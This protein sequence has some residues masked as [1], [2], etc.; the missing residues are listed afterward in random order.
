MLHST[1]TR[2]QLI[3]A[4]QSVGLVNQ[5]PPEDVL[6][7]EQAEGELRFVRLEIDRL[8][9]WLDEYGVGNLWQ[10]NL[11]GGRPCP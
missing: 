10:K 3:V 1:A 6:V 11:V 7:V 2:A 8:T 9:V 5:C 4:T